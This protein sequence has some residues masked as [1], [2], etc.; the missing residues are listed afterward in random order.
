MIYLVDIQYNNSQQNINI[1]S[2]EVTII[3]V[4]NNVDCKVLN[5]SICQQINSF[6]SKNHTSNKREQITIS[7]F[8]LVIH[9]NVK[10]II[11]SIR[12]KMCLCYHK[13][14]LP[15]ETGIEKY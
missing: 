13:D 10:M 8:P 12:C 1:L 14:F 9:L 2:T 15:I 3:V 4:D 6:N 11:E 7:F 5:I